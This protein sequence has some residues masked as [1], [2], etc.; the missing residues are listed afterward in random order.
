MNLVIGNTLWNTIN[1]IPAQYNYLDNDIDCDVAI[2][3]GGVT[4]ALCAYYLSA[5]G[6]N[7]VMVDKSIFGYSSTSASTSILQYEIDNDLYIMKE[8]MGDE[9]AISAFK[10]CY[11]AIQDISNILTKLDDSCDFNLTSCLY[12]SAEEKDIQR[13]TKEFEARKEAGFNVDY[14]DEI[15]GSELFSFPIKAGIYSKDGAAY[16]DPYRFTHALIRYCTKKGLKA[17]ENTEVTEININGNHVILNTEKNFKIKA[18]KYIL[19]V[20]YLGKNYVDKSVVNLS[21][22]FNIVTKPVNGFDSWFNKCI[23]RDTSDP[24]TYL[25]VTPDNRIIIGGED[26]SLGGDRSKVSTLSDNNDLLCQEK[27][28]ILQD[29]LKAMF[30]NITDITIEYTFNGVFGDTKDGL[31]YAGIYEGRPN[32]YL[33]LGYGSNG[34]LYSTLGAQLIRDLYL[35]EPNSFTDLFSFNR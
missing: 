24:Y 34:I 26:L 18:K 9:P 21:R 27:Y 35:G 28:N 5:A 4:G 2:I 15:S 7:T 29:R 8:T 31:P 20:G 10:L 1:K 12:Y 25:R 33:N 13:L 30:P 22:S 19:A 3:G 14:I 32:C 17:F 23:I 16:I 11:K 6:V